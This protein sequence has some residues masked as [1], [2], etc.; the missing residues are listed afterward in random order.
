MFQ[1]IYADKWH[2][3]GSMFLV[4]HRFKD[5]FLSPCH[6]RLCYIYVKIV[7]TRNDIFIL[8]NL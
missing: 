7:L 5:M 2:G 3:V 1:V 4:V 6:T 8:Q